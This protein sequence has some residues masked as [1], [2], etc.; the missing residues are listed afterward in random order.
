MD[1]KEKSDSARTKLENLRKR[2]EWVIETLEQKLK[3]NGNDLCKSLREYV[4]K[5][6]VKRKLTTDWDISD[7][8]SVDKGLGNWTWLKMKLHEAFYDKLC[9]CIIAWDSERQVIDTIETEMSTEIK[10]ELNLLQEELYQIEQE[11]QGESCST[12]EDYR[13]GSL[14]KSRKMSCVDLGPLSPLR[15]SKATISEPKLPMKLAGRLIYPVK[16]IITNIRHKAKVDNFRNNP[17]KMAENRA[18]EFYTELLSQPDD[19]DTGFVPFV[20]YLLERPKEYISVL[21]KK[22]PYFI[23]SN[24]MGLDI[25]QQSME[26]EKENQS[27]YEHMMTD[28]ENLRRALNEYGEGY[29]FVDDFMRDEIQ[30]R[31][32]NVDG[33]AVS[34]TFNVIDFLESDSKVADVVRKRDIHGLWTVTY[35]GSLVRNEQELPIAIRCYLPSSKVDNTFR[36]V[37]KLR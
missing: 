10:I 25:I 14:R 16:T 26:S 33:E 5:D 11:M 15:Y 31:R 27:D 34:V 37:A 2:S 24:Q 7:L 1:L 36:E 6:S 22:I 19:S 12:E 29:I 9:N 17:I 35:C 30:I 28:V 21:K 13:T 4:S 32:T 8:P 23:L 20:E 18:K 3:D